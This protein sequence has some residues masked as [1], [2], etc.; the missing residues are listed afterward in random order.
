ME[1]KI[2][3]DY[4][5]DSLATQVMKLIAESW[6]PLG[7]IAVTAETEDEYGVWAQAMI[8][9]PQGFVSSSDIGGTIG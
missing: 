5:S 4:C 3:T 8:R 9:C 1:Y 2:L 7:G 6:V